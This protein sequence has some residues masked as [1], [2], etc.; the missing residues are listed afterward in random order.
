M[1]LL[2]G[3]PG[4]GRTEHLA[5]PRA[6]A[7]APQVAR[8]RRPTSLDAAGLAL[9]SAWGPPQGMLIGNDE[10]AAVVQQAPDLFKRVASVDLRD[11]VRAVREFR[12][13]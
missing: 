11:P 9:L 4:R 7:A 10:V 2:I 8:Q 6:G 5:R 13:P 1:L 12:R 3:A